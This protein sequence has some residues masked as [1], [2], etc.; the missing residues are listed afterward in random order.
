MLG[1]SWIYE[2]S[3]V[4]ITQETPGH[5]FSSH[6]RHHEKLQFPPNHRT[7]EVSIKLSSGQGCHKTESSF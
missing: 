4:A 6:P 7:L 1:M 3:L 2:V 5:L